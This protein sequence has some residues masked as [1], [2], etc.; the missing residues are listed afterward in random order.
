MKNTKK[1]T[2]GYLLLVGVLIGMVAQ[3]VSDES[4]GRDAGV[5]P[6]AIADPNP[7]LTCNEY[8]HEWNYDVDNQTCWDYDETLWN[9]SCTGSS[10]YSNRYYCWVVT[11][12]GISGDASP[13]IFSTV[14]TN[15]ATRAQM[16]WRIMN[17]DKVIFYTASYQNTTTGETC[18]FPVTSNVKHCKVGDR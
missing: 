17:N 18:S 6:D 4:T 7:A 16:W 9:S 2:T 1:S 8:Y 13:M 15:D 14:L 5:I 11:I 3:C 12:P 10:G